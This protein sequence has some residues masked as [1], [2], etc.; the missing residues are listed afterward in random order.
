MIRL[1][2]E[3][4]DR[5][6]ARRTRLPCKRCLV[7][8]SLFLMLDLGRKEQTARPRLIEPALNQDIPAVIATCPIDR[9]L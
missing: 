5:H 9:R 4:C 2:F 1:D 3:T 6:I 7:A 8:L